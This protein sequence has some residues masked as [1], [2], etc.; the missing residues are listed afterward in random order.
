MMLRLLVVSICF[1]GIKEARGIG[2]C[3]RIYE[4]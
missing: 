3:N 1:G 2:V 4:L